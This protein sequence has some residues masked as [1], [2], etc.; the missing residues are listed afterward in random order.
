M[1]TDKLSGTYFDHL[2]CDMPRA[3]MTGKRCFGFNYDDF[4][5]DGL[6]I[7]DK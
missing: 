3:I 6:N 2:Y 4:T 5:E 1:N 7:A